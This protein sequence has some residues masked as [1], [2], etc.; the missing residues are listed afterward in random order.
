M[1]KAI[2]III[3]LFFFAPSGTLLAA[4]AE[5]LLFRVYGLRYANDNFCLFSTWIMAW[6]ISYGVFLFF[7]RRMSVRIVALFV[8]MG[9][10]A[11]AFIPTDFSITGAFI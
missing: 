3:E 10:Q 7:E 8:S 1:K 9:F 6:M 2:S 11:F 4:L 5:S